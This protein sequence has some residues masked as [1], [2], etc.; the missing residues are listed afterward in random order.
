VKRGWLRFSAATLLSLAVYPLPVQGE[1]AQWEGSGP[2][3]VRNFQPLQ[4]IFL[5]MP[6]ER[7][8]VLKKGA[9]DLRVEMA[10]S[11]S[12]FNEIGRASCR[13]RV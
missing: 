12:V 2:F 10:D 1:E 13:E 3:P 6:G 9:L 4:L 7:A 5:G 8:A 11:S